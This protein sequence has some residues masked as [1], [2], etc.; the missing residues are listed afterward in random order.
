MDLSLQE[1]K[2][3]FIFVGSEDNNSIVDF[4]EEQINTILGYIDYLYQSPEARK[5]FNQINEPIRV[6]AW[7]F[8]GGDKYFGTNIFDPNPILAFYMGVFSDEYTEEFKQEFEIKKFR[9]GY[10]SEEGTFVEYD[11]RLAFM[12]ELIHTITGLTDNDDRRGF[13]SRA[14]SAGPTQVVA[15]RI[16]DDLNAPS[17]ISY[18]GTTDFHLPNED[19]TASTIEKGTQYTKG[20]LANSE[21]PEITLGVFATKFS[22]ADTSK[23]DPKTND[24][25]ISGGL[26]GNKTFITGAGNDYLYGGR[27]N[28]SLNSGSDNDYLYGGRGNDSLDGGMGEDVAEFS[29]RFKDYD[30]D[31]PEDSEVITIDHVRGIEPGEFSDGTDTLKNIEWGIFDGKRKDLGISNL[32]SSEEE[33]SPRVIPLP[34]TDGVEKTDSLEV[35]G[36]EQP[37]YNDFTLE[38][39]HVSLTAP[40]AMLD[41]DVDFTLNISPFEQNSEYNVVYIFD[42]SSSTNSSAALQT[43]K[44]AY[45]DLTNYFID[46][47]I[48]ENINFSL[49]SFSRY[50]TIQENLSANEIIAAIENTTS[51]TQNVGTAYRDALTKADQFFANSALNRDNTTNLAYF[52]SDGRSYPNGSN[53]ND[54][55][56]KSYH[57]KAIDLQEF[58]YVQAF[59]LDIPLN[60][61][62]AN[63]NPAV[64]SQ[65]N[66]V[67]SNGGVIVTEASELTTEISQSGLAGDVQEINILV[68]GE[69]V[70][71]IQPSQLTDSPFGLTYEGSVDE[72]DVSIDAENVVTAEVVFNNGL[73][74]TSI[75]HT[76]TA[77]EGEAVDGDGN[78]IAQSGDGDEDPFERILDGGDRDDEIILGYADLGANSGAGGDEIIANRRDNVLDG[79]AGND[80]ISAYGGDDTITTG[81]GT[82]KVNGGE[83]IDTAVYNDVAYGNGS[84]VSLAKVA[85]SVSYND[86]DTL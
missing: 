15:N 23:N 63:D 26:Q 18:D 64:A 45:R 68:D 40:V 84:A 21:N 51:E 50:A 66:Y 31:K 39:P 29:E 8:F 47:D 46:T 52:V 81:A 77:G 78:D 25:F 14:D 74:A 60:D 33:S 2:D 59:G 48:A 65:I 24:L 6:F 79:G 62:R 54:P 57:S 70:D 73:P 4:T 56:A 7:R 43:T 3:K 75:E 32:V 10:I 72:L 22:N 82:D 27:G 13:T 44:D 42:R 20:K 80:T 38:S 11:V 41:G 53:Y 17:R 5:F 1:V 55:Y 30:Y 19:P 61:G 36:V 76:V 49:V 83:G 58:A 37:P 34:L 28:D 16:H 86:T 67:D 12:H 35:D 85:N 71:T 69:I 9:T